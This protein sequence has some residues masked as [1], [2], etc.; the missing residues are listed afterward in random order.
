MGFV[1]PTRGDD[2]KKNLLARAHTD[3]H[4]LSHVIC[5]IF[6]RWCDGPFRFHASNNSTMTRS[7]FIFD[8]IYFVWRNIYF[9]KRNALCG[10][11]ITTK[12]VCYKHLQTT[13]TLILNIPLVWNKNILFSDTLNHYETRN[14]GERLNVEI[15]S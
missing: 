5:L 6:V 1:R 13:S 10:G 8:F 7:V 12:C 4:T 9:T 3:S 15:C 14:N 2:L 11:Q